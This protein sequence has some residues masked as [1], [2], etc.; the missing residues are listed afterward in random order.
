[1]E[2]VKEGNDPSDYDVDK[3]DR[4]VL[5]I[6]MTIFR[7]CLVV[8]LLSSI[9][10]FA[11]DNKETPVQVADKNL[12]KIV[13]VQVEYIEVPHETMTALLSDPRTSTNDTPLRSKLQE[14]VKEG[15]G[16]M[17]E[18]Q[19][20]TARSGQKAMSESVHEFIYP[21]DY[22]A[23][24]VPCGNG[25]KA[26]PPPKAPL[27]PV[28][29][30][31]RNLGSTLEIEPTVGENGKV[32]DLR[33]L[34]MLLYHTGNKVWHEETVGKD[35]YKMQM[36][37]IY[38]ISADTSMTLITGQSFLMAAVSPKDEKGE[39]DFTKKVLI[40]VRADVLAVGK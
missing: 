34:P 19:I 12:S 4:D 23:P 13:R 18:T 31:T 27:T 17:L 29:W 1:M 20:V 5:I 14:L 33:L 10:G 22:V 40:F 32:V 28:A 3:R 11:Q 36:P 30:E 8:A 21:I 6:F 25:D 15:K 24:E 16:K 9:L 38:K 37:D 35:T 2:K 26:T 7:T 39:V